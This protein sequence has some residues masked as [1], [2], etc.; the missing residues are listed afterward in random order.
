MV[1]MLA[2]PIVMQFLISYETV[3]KIVWIAGIILTHVYHTDRLT[4]KYTIIYSHSHHGGEG[5]G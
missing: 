5:R 4:N 3:P 1:C 2:V